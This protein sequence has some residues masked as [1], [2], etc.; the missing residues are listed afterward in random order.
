MSHGLAKV[1]EL[2]CFSGLNVVETAQALGVS[3]SIYQMRMGDDEGVA[4][5]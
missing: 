1:V 5:S 2:R 4:A 3:E